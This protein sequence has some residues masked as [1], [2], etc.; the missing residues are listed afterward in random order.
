MQ[1]KVVEPVRYSDWA[2]PIE[3]VLKADVEVRVCGDYKLTV[4]RVSP[5]FGAMSN[6]CLS[7]CG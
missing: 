2:T 4:N 1:S 3:P 7:S 6:F 5:P